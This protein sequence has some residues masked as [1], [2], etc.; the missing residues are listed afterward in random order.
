MRILVVGAGSIGERHVRCFATIKGVEIGVCDIN[1]D[2]A[3]KISE[4]YPVIEIGTKTDDFDLR[5]YDAAVVCTPA[6]LHIKIANELAGKGLHLLIEKPLSISTDGVTEL[7]NISEQLGI[8]VAVGY[9]FRSDPV[10][11]SMRESIQSGRFGLPKQ[12]IGY[13]GQNFPYYRPEY[14]GTYYVHKEQ[15]GGAIQDAIT[16]LINASEWLVGPIERLVSDA[17]KLF[18]D[19]GSDV[20][21]TV[22]VIAQH[23]N[24]IMGLYGL[25]QFQMPNECVITVVCTEGTLRFEKHNGLWK[26]SIEP[27]QDWKEEKRVSHHPDDFFTMQAKNFIDSIEGKELPKCDLL[28]GI[29]SLKVNLAIIKSSMDGGFVST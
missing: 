14:R 21:D 7:I 6:N 19:H 2:I 27:E 15:G 23:S 22:H 17:N 4:R 28:S 12:I 9:V 10:L 16:H 3:R 8:I 1:L 11:S 18:L 25:N 29:Q 13:A 20:E 26:S 24:G 5:N